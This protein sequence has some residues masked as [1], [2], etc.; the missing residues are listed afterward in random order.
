MCTTLLRYSVCAAIHHTTHHHILFINGVQRGSGWGDTILMDTILS[1]ITPS[2]Y[3]KELCA[4]IILAN[5]T[6]QKERFKE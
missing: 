2:F 3:F 4:E 1:R 5:I 6:Q